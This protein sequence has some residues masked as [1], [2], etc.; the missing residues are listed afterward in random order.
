MCITLE[1]LSP[2]FKP[3]RDHDKYFDFV[4]I[5]LA[6]YN[7]DQSKRKKFSAHLRQ[8]FILLLYHNDVV[9]KY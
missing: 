2:G 6:F 7:F 1:S 3:R 9:K 8:H 5:T 4:F